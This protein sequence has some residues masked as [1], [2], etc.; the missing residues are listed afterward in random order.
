MREQNLKVGRIR[1]GAARELYLLSW[2]WTWRRLKWQN[3]LLCAAQKVS[4]GERVCEAESEQRCS[5]RASLA[6]MGDDLALGL[7]FSLNA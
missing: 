6:M 5:A 3:T 7:G 2:S 4:P 1:A